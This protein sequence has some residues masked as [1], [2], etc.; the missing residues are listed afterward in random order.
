MGLPLNF[1]KEKLASVL[2]KLFHKV[3]QEG[4]PPKQFY[5]INISENLIRHLKERKL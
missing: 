5:E 4:T 2:F 3:K 1:F